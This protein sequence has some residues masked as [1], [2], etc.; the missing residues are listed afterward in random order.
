MLKLLILNSHRRSYDFWD[1]LYILSR[2]HYVVIDED[3]VKLSEIDS[4][5]PYKLHVARNSW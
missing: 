1:F 2:N 5:E 3:T 4:R